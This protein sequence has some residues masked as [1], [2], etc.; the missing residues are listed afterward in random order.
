MYS[1]IILLLFALAPFHFSWAVLS[2]APG[3]SNWCAMNSTFGG[4]IHQFQKQP[5]NADQQSFRPTACTV[6]ASRRFL[7]SKPSN[8]TQHK[9]L[10]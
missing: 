3:I 7:H 8:L 10:D 5:C 4:N 9:Y 6:R 1:T 2:P